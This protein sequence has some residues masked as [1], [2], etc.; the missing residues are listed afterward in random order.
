MAAA[1]GAPTTSSKI[2]VETCAHTK[3]GRRV[4]FIPGARRA[5]IV[6]RKLV[7]AM[8]PLIAQTMMLIAQKSTPRLCDW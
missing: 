5:T 3:R 7:E 8:M 1:S 2:E 4:S 6:V